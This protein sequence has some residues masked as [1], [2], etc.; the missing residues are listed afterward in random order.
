MERG[1]VQ[2]HHP[3][4]QVGEEP[5]CVAQERA[6][7]FHASQLLEKG[8][9]DDFRVREALE[10]FVAAGTGVEMGVSVVDEAK[11]H[12]EGLF[13]LGEAWG[14]V[15]LGHLLLLGEGRL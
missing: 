9:G 11:E 13:R 6:F 2:P 5:L 8:E 3:G 12:C 1:R 7:A 4:E 14:M 15:G 10:G